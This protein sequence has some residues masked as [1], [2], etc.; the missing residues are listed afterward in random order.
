MG[1]YYTYTLLIAAG[2]SFLLTP[3]IRKISLLK[4]F[5]DRPGRRKIHRKN[6]PT[7]GGIAI[8]I[9]FFVAML[10]A[11]RFA[12]QHMQEFSHKFTG[13]CIGGFIIIGLGIFDDIR[14]L[15]ARLKFSVQILAALILVI[16]G[17]QI[18][19]ITS[20]VGDKISLGIFGLLFTVFWIVGITNAINLLDGLDGLAAGITGIVA[21]FLSLVAMK[22]HNFVVAFLASAL[23]GSAIGFL[24]FN[25]YPAKIFMGNAGSMF[26]G[27]LLSAIAIEGYQKS[28]TVIALIVPII[29]MGIPIIDTSLAIVRRLIKK[30]RIFQADKEHIHHHMLIEEESQ[31]RTVLS[32]Y[33]LSFC[34]GLIA[35]SF[36]GFKGIFV[37]I[38][39]VLV[40]LVTFNWMKESGFLKF[41]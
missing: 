38:A 34:F 40:V 21:F 24:P 9:S 32:L 41:R 3:I 18:A 16:Y 29:A 23:V 13:L 15:N 26:L 39:L 1:K 7:L 5:F 2:V 28:R 12:P 30:R 25:F 36:T 37:I 31:R 17:F 20:P 35:F 14:G 19:E 8:C 33:F 22:Q 27:F 11:F 10:M 6:M 4:G